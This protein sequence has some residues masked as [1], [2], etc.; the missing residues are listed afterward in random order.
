MFTRMQARLG[1]IS[2]GAKDVL[3]AIRALHPATITWSNVPDYFLP[4]EFHALSRA[5]SG[6]GTQ[7]VMYSMNWIRDVK[8][9]FH[10]DYSLWGSPREERYDLSLRPS[11]AVSSMSW[12]SAFGCFSIPPCHA[13]CIGAARPFR[14]TNYSSFPFSVLTRA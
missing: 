8:G 13:F 14:P 10:V 1:V 2:P 4:A 6:P 3:A 7:H 5:C 9:A 11:L 12:L